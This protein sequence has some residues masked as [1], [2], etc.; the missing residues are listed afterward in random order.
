[1]KK[2]ISILVLSLTMTQGAWTQTALTPNADKTVWT[3]AS[4]PANDIVLQAEYYTDLLEGTDNSTWITD[5]DEKTV[6]L[7]LG[8]TLSAGS[9]NTFA[10]PFDINTVPTGWV[11]KKL[12][13]ASVSGSTLTLTFD[14][15]S[16]IE[17]GKPYLVKV[18]SAVANPTF[19]GVTISKTADPKECGD[20][21][22]F[23]PT[24]GKTTLP[25]GKKNKILF[26]AAGNTLKHPSEEEQNLKGFRAYFMLGEAANAINSF[27][28]NL[29]D[30]EV[31][32]VQ[33]ISGANAQNA[34]DDKAYNLGGQ[35][36]SAGYKGIVIVNG[37]KVVK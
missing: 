19:D 32:G 30:G 14:D 24:L 35:R 33:M 5:N 13:D 12:T 3:L 4:M 29:G 6:D 1:M 9:W 20:V 25:N 27:R 18:E 7:W 8:R 15:A 37:Q 10:V 36:V 26:L 34:G 2:L 31:T 11:V 17:A 21:I 23:V 28:L 22:S 16:S